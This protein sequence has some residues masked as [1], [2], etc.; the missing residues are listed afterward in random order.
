MKSR[1]MISADELMLKP[2]PE[3]TRAAPVRFDELGLDA[4][5]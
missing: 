3:I 5:D 2:I 1:I 4:N